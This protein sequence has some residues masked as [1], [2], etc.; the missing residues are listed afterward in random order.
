MGEESQYGKEKYMKLTK[1]AEVRQYDDKKRRRI[2]RKKGWIVSS[3]C[4]WGEGGGIHWHKQKQV[5]S[6]EMKM[7]LLRPFSIVMSYG[8]CAFYRPIND[9]QLSFSS[10]LSL[11]F[12]SYF[13]V[14]E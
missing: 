12:C 6:C 11:L 4:V 5:G 7:K 10:R 13:L 14:T 2:S 8:P 9:Q 1:N 3:V